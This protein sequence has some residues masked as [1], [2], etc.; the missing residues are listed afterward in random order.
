MTAFMHDVAR[1]ALPVAIG[2]L[3]CTVAAAAVQVKSP[4]AT[5]S[6]ARATSC[7]KVVMS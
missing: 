3:T 5:G 6:A 2:L 4:I 7:M 1:A